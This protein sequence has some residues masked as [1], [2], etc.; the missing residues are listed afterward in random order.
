[1][2]SIIRHILPLRVLN[3]IKLSEVTVITIQVTG[4]KHRMLA[5]NREGLV[6]LRPRAEVRW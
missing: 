4:Q 2:F 5:K 6:A 1:M 3:N